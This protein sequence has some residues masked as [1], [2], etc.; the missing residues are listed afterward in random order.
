MVRVQA[1]FETAKSRRVILHNNMVKF[2]AVL[3]TRLHW[4]VQVLPN[5]TSYFYRDKFK[6]RNFNFERIELVSKNFLYCC[7]VSLKGYLHVTL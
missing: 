3:D 5:S 6:F 4:H 2:T 7:D 1:L